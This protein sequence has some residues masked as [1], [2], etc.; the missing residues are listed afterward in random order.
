MSGH[1]KWSS[2][3]HKKAITDA[4]KGKAFTKAAN[5]I[6][7]AAREGGGD[8]ETNFRLRL[9][10]EKAREVNMPQA[11]IEKAIKKGTG[12]EKGVK[13]E[14]FTYEGY[15][16]GGVALLINMMTDN[17]NRAAAEVRATLTK[18]G[19][20]LGESG[21]VSWMFSEKGQLVVS[22]SSFSREEKDELELVVIDAGASDFEES[23]GNL[24]IYCNPINLEKVK[25]A[26]EDSG[27][28]IESTEV[29]NVAQNEIKITDE[30]TAG[31]ILKLLENLEDLEDV[32]NVESNADIIEE[33]L[34]K[35]SL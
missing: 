20:N 8:N 35:I 13:I 5:L 26:F 18:F 32:K 27:Q 2:I 17:R 28:K 4:R 16:P 25:K 10:V 34:S 14:E 33:I 7:I 11:N 15:G 24:F 12:E 22:V 23:E 3:K 9:A 6:A 31:Q 1:S 29:L 21:S 30:K 19:G